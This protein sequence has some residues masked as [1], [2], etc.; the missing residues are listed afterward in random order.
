MHG[1]ILAG[2]R[3]LVCED[4]ALISLDIADAFTKTGAQVV[5][6]PS[7]RNALAAL[8]EGVISA[9]ILDHSLRDGDCSELC[10]RLKERNIPF[11]IY[12]GFDKLDK[13]HGAAV[14]VSKPVNMDV[15]VTT[16]VGLLQR[17]RALQ[18][19]PVCALR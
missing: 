18:P 3:I 7:Q 16:V 9:A 6:S 10:A 17:G 4:E 2:H 11:V 1:T 8:E 5:T 13:T 14:H 19:A 15:L 12:S